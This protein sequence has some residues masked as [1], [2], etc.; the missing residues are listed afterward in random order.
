M[1]VLFIPTALPIGKIHRHT[2]VEILLRFGNAN[3]LIR[4]VEMR[5]HKVV[6]IAQAKRIDTTGKAGRIPE[7]VHY[8]VIVCRYAMRGYSL[9]PVK[10]VLPFQ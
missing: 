9:Y 5:L 10:A 4:Q 2:A 8:N 1:P 7:L 6:R 3:A